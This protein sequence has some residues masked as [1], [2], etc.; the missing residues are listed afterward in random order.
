LTGGFPQP[1]DGTGTGGTGHTP[2]ISGS[3][4]SN[5]MGGTGHGP[6]QEDGS[7]IGGTGHAPWKEAIDGHGM[8]GTGNTPSQDGSG[9]GGTGHDTEVEGVITGFASVCVNGLELHYQPTTPVAINGRAGS[10]KDLAIGQVI[11]AQ[12]AGVGDQLAISRLQVR[13]LMV[14][15]LQDINAGRAQVMGQTIVLDE[16]ARL[17]AGLTRGQK[18]AISGFIGA[19]G[20]IIATRLDTVPADT[21]DSITGEVSLNGQGQNMIA[22]VVL[23]GAG[24]NIK[25]SENVRAEGRYDNGSFHADRVERDELPSPAERFVIQGPVKEVGKDKINVGGKQF[26]VDPSAPGKQEL[27]HA[28]QWVRVEGQRRGQDMLINKIEVQEKILP[29]HSGTNE[30]SPK[31]GAAQAPRGTSST[32]E[33]S[34]KT[35]SSERAESPERHEEVEK[36]E[37]PERPEKV[38][39]PERPEKVEAPERPE[40]VEAPE[41]P[42]RVESPERVERTER[43]EPR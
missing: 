2:W 24:A 3:A 5:G 35:E 14:A 42:E 32:G 1:R 11:R 7:G 30:R 21:P 43:T 36:P 34:E 16:D 4:D 40:K 29:S 19:G 33:R 22:G 10:P 12:A 27:P 28:G 6:L 8:G 17:P 18:V 25:P 31:N 39:A 23:D 38:E 41:R 20:I 15:P 9:M 26:A 13:H 37:T